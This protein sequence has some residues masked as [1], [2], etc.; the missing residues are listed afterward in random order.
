MPVLR[1]TRREIIL[2][3]EY[4]IAEELKDVAMKLVRARTGNKVDLGAPRTPCSRRIVV[5]LN[6][7]FGNRE[8]VRHNKGVAAKS[9]LVT[10]AV[11]QQVV[12]VVS[13]SIH[14]KIERRVRPEAGVDDD[15]HGDAGFQR[16]Q[17][18]EDPVRQRQGIHLLSGDCVAFVC[19]NGVHDC[20]RL[21]DR[22]LL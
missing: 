5:V 20:W 12:L 13:N 11:N 16:H 1:G 6:T 15:R 3:V 21:G 17:L 2:G 8:Q 19:R 9:V 22:D 14:G 18:R 4:V 7:D 10:Y